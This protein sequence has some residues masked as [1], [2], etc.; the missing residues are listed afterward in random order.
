MG[1]SNIYSQVNTIKNLQK[2]VT[3]GISDYMKEQERIKAAQDK[4]RKTLE[5][6]TRVDLWNAGAKEKWYPGSPV[7]CPWD[8]RY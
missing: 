4:A 5:F 7:R 2:S 1:D 6:N 8:P 3:D